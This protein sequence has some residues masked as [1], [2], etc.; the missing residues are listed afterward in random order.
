MKER[1]FQKVVVGLSVLTVGMVFQG[2]LS[3]SH[4]EEIKVGVIS[5]ASGNLADLGGEERKG[6][7]MATEEFNA[8]GGVLGEKIR[9]YTEDSESDPSVAARKA[10][11]LIEGDGVD[12]LIGVVSSSA[13]IAVGEVAERYGKVYICTNANSDEITAAAKAKRVVF[14]VPPDMAMALRANGPWVADH[15]GK[16]WYFFTHDY[17]A[18]WSA[19]AWAR[20]VLRSKGGV[21]LG[22]IKVPMGTRDFSSFLLKARAAKPDVLVIT[23][24]G[25][26]GQALR[27]QIYEFGTYKEMKIFFTLID[28]EDSYSMGKEKAVGYPGQEWN[29]QIGAPGVDEFRAWYKKRWPSSPYPEPGVN[30]YNGY[31]GMRELLRAVA[32]AGTT[33]TAN[34]IKALEGHVFTDS[35]KHWP[36][37]IREWDHQFLSG[38]YLS[39][40]KRPS[41]MKFKS[42][43]FDVI[44]K[45]DGATVARTMEENPVKLGPYPQ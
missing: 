44:S 12:F 1:I 17:T 28:P 42:D 43:F 6:I 19:T 25:F 30:L 3:P 4:G 39:R 15:L 38:I 37:K 11:R 33:R 13:A 41:E 45:T 26:D 20:Q 18:G 29:A 35:L 24:V 22:E 7:T 5:P 8:Q 31:I 32:R 36:V 16:R 14:R 34:V 9:L 10:R 40:E 27:E 2:R 21:D 23:V